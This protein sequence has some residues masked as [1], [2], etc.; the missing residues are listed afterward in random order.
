MQEADYLK[1]RVDHQ[2]D[3]YNRKAKINKQ[4]HLWTNTN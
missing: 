3:W 4:C 1:E 2:I